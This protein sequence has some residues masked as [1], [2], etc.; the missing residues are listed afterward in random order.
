[1]LYQLC[2]NKIMSLFT[3][4]KWER[5][6]WK[7]R[8]FSFQYTHQLRDRQ[9]R[10]TENSKWVEKEGVFFVLIVFMNQSVSPIAQCIKYTDRRRRPILLNNFSTWLNK[11]L[12]QSNKRWRERERKSGKY[13]Y[14]KRRKSRMKRKG[15]STLL[16]QRYKG[17]RKFFH[18]KHNN[19]I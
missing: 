10:K 15:Y 14:Y 11:L 3:A 17:T 5:S 19:Y 13:Y 9:T 2:N 7:G 12:H 1:M 16:H 4:S 6:E 18:E 8:L